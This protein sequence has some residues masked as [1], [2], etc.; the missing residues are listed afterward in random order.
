[1]APRKRA[2]AFV[3][4]QASAPSASN[5]AAMR[6]LTVAS[7]RI[8]PVRRSRNTQQWVMEHGANAQTTPHA[9]HARVETAEEAHP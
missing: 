7:R 8:S 1:M 5:A 2:A 3:S 4:Y 9:E 6:S